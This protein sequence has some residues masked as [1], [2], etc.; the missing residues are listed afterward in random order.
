VG[1]ESKFFVLGENPFGVV[2]IVRRADMMWVGCQPLHVRSKVCRAWH[3]TKLLFPLALD[4]GG[5]GGVTRERRL[6]RS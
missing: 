4:A 1:V 3:C 6:V 5:I 2:F